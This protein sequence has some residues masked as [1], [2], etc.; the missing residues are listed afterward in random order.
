M[1]LIGQAW[2]A[3]GLFPMAASRPVQARDWPEFGQTSLLTPVF[4]R[5]I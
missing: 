3:I 4:I 1:G 5:S 2:T